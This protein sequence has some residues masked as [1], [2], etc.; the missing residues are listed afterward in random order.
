MKKIISILILS[1]FIFAG[2]TKVLNQVPQNSIS[3]TALTDPASI[4]S[5]LL[6][7]Y[8]ADLSANYTGLRYFIFADLYADNI[9]EVGTFSDFQQVANKLI[10][11][12]NS[13]VLSLWTQIYFAINNAN[14]V[15]SAAT[16]N[17]STTFTDKNSVIA[18]ARCLR[19]FH[20]FNLL[21]YW[22]GQE[23][24]YHQGPD[25]N[26]KSWGVPLRTKPTLTGADAVPIARAPEDS[27]WAQIFRDLDPTS[28][29]ANLPV[30]NSANS[31]YNWRFDQKSANAL[32]ARAYL[33]YGNWASAEASAT[34]VITTAGQ[35]LVSLSSYANLYGN[36]G[37]K[38]EVIFTQPYDPT[39]QSSV[40]F[41]YF[42]TGRRGRNEISS[43]LALQAAH[44]AGDI[45][46]E[47]N[48]TTSASA[49]VAPAG[50]TLKYTRVSTGDDY[51]PQIRL[52]EIYLIR[53][54]ARA[55]QGNTSG[56]LADLN[57][58]RARAGL[59][60]SAAVTQSDILTAILNERRVELAHEGHRFFDLRRFQQLSVI[61]I[62]TA[63]PT[64]SYKCRFP[65]PLQ[66]IN[67]SGSVL[68]QNPGY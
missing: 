46:K 54:E 42:T 4:R 47:I 66:E 5:A 56:A 31:S 63:D 39:N 12:D 24:G 60:S 33:Y 61:G 20:Y 18:E 19:A 37:P 22:G 11:S 9:S 29:I 64:Q 45:R 41:F 17:N 34:S 10:T 49:A 8:S 2:C 32:L 65:I 7:A 48:F 14:T 62:N 35:S 27:V 36:L 59:A 43:S 40:A 6:G 26:G 13:S 3:A 44:E 38:S 58:V 51:V 15:I 52:A 1:I 25:A 57:V 50:K 53:A 16:N 55:R 23:N 21:R 68:V 67:N 28:V 30:S